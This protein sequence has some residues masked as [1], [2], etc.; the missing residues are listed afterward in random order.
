MKARGEPRS[1]LSLR[2]SCGVPKFQTKH[3]AAA[4]PLVAMVILVVGCSGE[5]EKPAVVEIEQELRRPPEPQDK[6]L[7]MAATGVDSCEGDGELASFEV[8]EAA[9]EVVIKA[10]LRVDNGGFCEVR[11]ASD[12]FTVDLSKPL[13][14]RL[15]VDAS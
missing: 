1:P 8:D 5:S 15:I 14:R 6:V 12:S 4:L 3:L 7:H 2:K 11:E 13:G 10:A 9:E